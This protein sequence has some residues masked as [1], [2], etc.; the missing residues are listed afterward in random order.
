LK[1]VKPVFLQFGKEIF[2]VKY[3][4][5]IAKNLSS[6]F[7]E[8]EYELDLVGKAKIERIR[9][10]NGNEETTLSFIIDFEI[11]NSGYFTKQKIPY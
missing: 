8:P 3:P 5:V 11:C 2:R 7:S 10:V 6:M 9:D 4:S 1:Q